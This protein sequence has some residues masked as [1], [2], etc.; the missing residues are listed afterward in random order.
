MKNLK[1]KFFRPALMKRYLS[2][3]Q[4]KNLNNKELNEEK[5]K[6]FRN[7]VFLQMLIIVSAMLL[8]EI[9]AISGVNLATSNT[10][11]DFLFLV[12]GGSYVFVLWDL[13]RD[14][15]KNNTLLVGMFILILFGL[16]VAF[17]AVN[18]LYDFFPNE[19]A[20]RPYLFFVHSAL[21]I[22]ESTVIYHCVYDIF[23]GK[24]LS[25][26]KIWGSACIYL[27]IGISFG[28]VYDLIHI[29]H[30]E[31]MGIPLAQG[32]ESYTVCIYYSMT[33]IGGHDAFM[34][35]IPLI[36]NIGIIEAVWSNLFIVLLVGRLLGKPDATD[37][38]DDEKK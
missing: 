10:I 36:Q 37:D 24:K 22:V 38:D 34:D 33:I 19:D 7:I 4:R 1:L 20:K 27:M 9:L 25:V 29:V 18:P 16:G 31:S 35:A 30:P 13:L 15:T 2:Y 11:R 28:S 3:I 32:L 23:S 21:F 17:F 8:K 14:L 6:D 12:T 26:E 5:R